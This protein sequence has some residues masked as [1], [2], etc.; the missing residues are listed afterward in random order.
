[1]YVHSL[2]APYTINTMPEKTLLSFA[3]H[4]T[5]GSQL[6]SDSI[7]ADQVIAAFEK[8]GFDYYQLAEILQKE[9][10]ESFVKSWNELLVTIEAKDK[11]TQAQ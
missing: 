4:G 2:G 1:L 6:P 10:A 11:S 5:P 3:E 7:E 8:A 9:G